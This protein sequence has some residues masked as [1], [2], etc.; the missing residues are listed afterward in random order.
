MRQLAGSRF[1]TVLFR[2][3][4]GRLGPKLG[5]RQRPLGPQN[6]KTPQNFPRFGPS[7]RA[8]GVRQANGVPIVARYQLLNCE[9]VVYTP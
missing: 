1:R 3:V 5:P 9:K 8:P 7:Q 2:R 4:P 6:C